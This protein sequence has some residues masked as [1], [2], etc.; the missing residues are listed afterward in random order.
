MIKK[1][2]AVITAMGGYVPEGILSNADIEKVVNTNDEWIVSR[3]SIKERRIQKGENQATSDMIVPTI[4][5]I[6]TKRNLK[7]SDIE[8]IIVATVTPD[9][10][11]SYSF[12]RLR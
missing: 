9:A 10:N 8:C 12:Y 2:L 6:C 1:T 7:P 4:L 5:E 11:A 3:T